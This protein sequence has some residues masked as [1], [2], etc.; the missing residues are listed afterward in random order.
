MLAPA[1]A[2]SAGDGSK[3]LHTG[4]W[5]SPGRNHLF[6]G[7]LA[8]GPAADRP[9]RPS[10]SI[11]TDGG[12]VVDSFSYTGGSGPGGGHC[13]LLQAEVLPEQASQL[14]GATLILRYEDLSLEYAAQLTADIES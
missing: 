12:P 11:S 13:W 5:L 9:K 4:L 7:V 2:G 6:I 10:I 8:E 1:F 14:P 3:V